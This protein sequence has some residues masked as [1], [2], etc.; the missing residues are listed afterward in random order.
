LQEQVQRIQARFARE[1]GKKR[2][3]GVLSAKPAT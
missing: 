2:Q 1:K 3:E